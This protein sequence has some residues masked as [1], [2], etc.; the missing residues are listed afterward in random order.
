MAED[1]V[2]EP[3]RPLMR[4]LPPADPFPVDM[5]GEVLGAAARAIN[6]RVQA[7][8]AICGQSVLGAAA[9]V[10]QGQADVM[11]PIGQ[12]QPR[13]LSLYLISIGASGERKSACDAEAMWQI[14]R[15]EE[16]LREQH[17]CNNF[18]YSNERA[19][20]DR[21]RK[22]A[23]QAGKGDRA[24][25]RAALDALGPEPIPP[26]VPM[27]TCPEPTYEGMCRLLAI[28][29]P[30]IGIFAAEGGQFVGG[31]GMSDEARCAPRRGSPRSGT[32]TRSVGCA[33]WRRKHDAARP[34]GVASFDVAA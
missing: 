25:I 13:P 29:Q 33:G 34:A 2:H 19:A 23:E 24:A 26:L 5:L 18:S 21:A 4:E 31:H 10:G 17:E 1:P 27:L 7:P 16:A 6:D 8:L 3:P 9:L 15:R 22:I 11:L 28:G 12:G 30:S 14:R 20:Y 32:A